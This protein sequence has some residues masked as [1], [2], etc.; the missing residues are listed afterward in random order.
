MT[1]TIHFYFMTYRISLVIRLLTDLHISRPC[2]GNRKSDIVLLS[3]L[4][5]LFK[6]DRDNK[7]K[8]ETWHL[9][10]VTTVC[11][12]KKPYWN[13]EKPNAKMADILTSLLLISRVY[14]T[15]NILNSVQICIFHFCVQWYQPDIVKSQILYTDL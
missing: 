6:H 9:V 15:H 8:I 1:F 14:S 13:S 7:N 5:S 4:S 3:L 10:H 2:L 11:S 12:Y